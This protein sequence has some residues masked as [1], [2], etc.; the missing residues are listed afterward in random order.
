M[1]LRRAVDALAV[2]L[3][4]PPTVDELAAELQISREEVV[5]A[6]QARDALMIA[7]LDRPADGP[8]G[9]SVAMGELLGGDDP[10]SPGSRAGS[11]PAGR[12]EPS[13]RV[14]AASSPCAS[15]GT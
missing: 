14:R 8:D 10:A 7:S 13:P 11:W 5:E 6:Y 9:E 12:S 1:A 2:G 3:R 15:A 4:G